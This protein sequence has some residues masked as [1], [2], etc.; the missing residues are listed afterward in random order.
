VALYRIDTNYFEAVNLSDPSVRSAGGEDGLHVSANRWTH[1]GAVAE[2]GADATV[3][4]VR[5]LTR[6]E[7]DVAPMD[8][9]PLFLASM[10]ETGVH[11]ED[12]TLV[13]SLPWQFQRSLAG[14]IFEVSTRP[15]DLAKGH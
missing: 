4:R 2:V 12:K 11:P 1:R 7:I 5:A 15:L 13:A 10:V 14:L 3:V 9:D 6:P 8:S